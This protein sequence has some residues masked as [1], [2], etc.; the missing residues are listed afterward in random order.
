MSLASPSHLS[1]TSVSSVALV[2]ARRGK[3]CLSSLTCIMRFPGLGDSLSPPASLMRRPLTSPTS[4]VLWSRG[5][6]Q[7]RRSRTRSLRTS[8]Q[9]PPPRGSSALSFRPSRVEPPLLWSISPT[10]QR[11]RQVRLSTLW[12]SFRPTKRR[13][14][15]RWMRGTRGW[16]SPLKLLRS[17]AGLPTWPFVL[18][19]IQRERLGAV[20]QVWWRLSAI[21]GWIW[22][23]S[24][25]RRRLSSS[26]PRSPA[27]A[28]SATRLTPLLISSGLLKRSRLRLSSSCLVGRANRPLPRP[29]GSARPP[30]R[31]QSVEWAIW[32]IPRRTRSGELVVVP[33]L[34]SAPASG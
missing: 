32:C 34:A 26:M 1:L 12:P 11:D 3:S 23:R 9:L 17:F 14:W 24:G 10:W 8:R 6:P 30:E 25:K 31:S 21:C 15:R 18:L 4:L 7:S 2:R 16:M 5:T 29:L 20:W 19:S 27:L 13:Y 22:Q 28:Y 33:M